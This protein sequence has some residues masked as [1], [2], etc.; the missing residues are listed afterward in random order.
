MPRIYKPG[1]NQKPSTSNLGN[2]IREQRLAKKMTLSALNKVMG[3]GSINHV[4]RLEH[5]KYA[6]FTENDQHRLCQVLGCDLSTLQALIPA[7]KVKPTPPTVFGILIRRNRE[8][9]GLSCPQLASKVG[10]TATVVYGW[11]SGHLTTI[12]KKLVPKLASAL[13]IP[14]G[15]LEPFTLG[16]GVPLG[17]Q[18]SPTNNPLG[19][20]VRHR[21]KQMNLSQGQL[22]EK[23]NVTRQFISMIELGKATLTND[24][25]WI[26]SIATALA[27]PVQ[28]LKELQE[29]RR[30]KGMRPNAIAAFITRHRQKQGMTQTG[31]AH[32]AGVTINIIFRLENGRGIIVPQELHQVAQAL[33]CQFPS[34]DMHE[35]RSS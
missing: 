31:L 10:L 6:T 25:Y 20:K 12:S 27:V 7:S 19:A 8:R 15:F 33:G 29:C 23:L 22:G 35:F 13:D 24:R 21:R 17:N 1:F 34:Y 2:Y 5:G 18:E 32:T 3:W 11:E 14:P 4:S 30:L 26:E 28:E 16:H 9:L